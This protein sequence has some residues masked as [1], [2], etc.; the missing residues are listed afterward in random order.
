MPWSPESRRS[1]AGVADSKA[2]PSLMTL[3]AVLIVVL[4]A[5]SLGVVSFVSYYAG[6]TMAP[7]D[8]LNGGSGSGGVA[9][10]SRRWSSVAALEKAAAAAA[11]TSLSYDSPCDEPLPY[12]VSA[13]SAALRAAT[14]P[15]SYDDTTQCE[16]L[17]PAC[18]TAGGDVLLY[19]PAHQPAD[20][21]YTPVRTNVTAALERMHYHVFWGPPEAEGTEPSSPASASAAA[22][23][24]VS[25]NADQFLNTMKRYEKGVG[26]RLWPGGPAAR[27]PV[28]F[29]SHCAAAPPLLL[30]WD[31]PENY[32]HAMAT[33]AALWHAASV[34]GAVDLGRVSLAVGLPYTPARGLPRWMAQPLAALLRTGAGGSEGGGAG[35]GRG[36][37]RPPRVVTALSHYAAAVAGATGGGSRADT[38]DDSS[39]GVEAPQ[40]PT[41]CYAAVPACAVSSFLKRPVP[42]MYAFMQALKAQLLLDRTAASGASQP[43]AAAAAAADGG[44][45]FAIG[46][47][48]TLRVLLAVRADDGSRRVLNAAALLADCA[49]AGTI[50]VGGAPVRVSCEAWAFGSGPRG[51][52]DDAAKLDGTDVLVGVHGAGLTNLGFLRPGATVIEARPSKFR[53]EN[54]DRFY[55]PLAASSGVLK[56]WGVVLFRDYEPKGRLEAAGVGNPDQWGR[57]RDVILPWRALAAALGEVL[58]L[59]VPEWA[60][61]DAAGRVFTEVAPGEHGYR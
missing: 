40:L 49:F 5:C 39:D 41:A 28:P 3:N 15:V 19:A 46:P 48:G 47:D 14:V 16:E 54:G 52:A 50:I 56:W 33:A 43:P 31:F 35:S 25:G 23:V 17:G 32:Y 27:P 57:D 10:V 7:C 8:S 30:F 20:G 13:L 18:V 4:A 53:G 42:G 6:V 34:A 38:D 59:T 61:R 51:L 60:A 37:A 45:P 36:V 29:A 24:A 44:R 9:H 1:G 26:L 11:P 55:R 2:P 22:A 12:D 21:R 58:P